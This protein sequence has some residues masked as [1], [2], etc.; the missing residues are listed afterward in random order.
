MTTILAKVNNTN[1]FMYNETDFKD[2]RAIRQKW[3]YH[4]NTSSERWEMKHE[5]PFRFVEFKSWK[6]FDRRK[7]DK[8]SSKRRANKLF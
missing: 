1:D 7:M 8:G 5:N 3:F 4:K 6:K 2:T